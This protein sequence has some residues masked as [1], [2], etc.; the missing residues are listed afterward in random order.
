[1]IFVDPT[2]IREGSLLPRGVAEVAIPLVGLEHNTGADLLIS[3]LNS[4]PLAK[5]ESPFQWKMFDKHLKRGIL[6][7]RKTGMDMFNSIPR[8][9]Y[10]LEKMIQWTTRPYLCWIRRDVWYSA[11]GILHAGRKEFGWHINSFFGARN[12]WQVEGGYYHEFDKD[13]HFSKWCFL[14]EKSL[15]NNEED[16]SF[17]R[18]REA[19]G[20][21]NPDYMILTFFKGIGTVNAKK[22]WEY[23]GSSIMASMFYL[24]VGDFS[25]GPK[26]VSVSVLQEANK[27][28]GEDEFSFMEKEFNNGKQ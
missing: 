10:I 25:N 7:Q 23:C 17:S 21:T 22:I 14:M 2:E 18:V 4:P 27:I 26:G 16:L 19:F 28:I 8:L 15:A 9:S 1:M 13:E 6:V 11:A 24:S 5:L 3:P 12:S 20:T